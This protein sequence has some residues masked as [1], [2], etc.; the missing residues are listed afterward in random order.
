MNGNLHY[1]ID[2]YKKFGMNHIIKWILPSL[3]IF[4]TFVSLSF[5]IEKIDK[6]LNGEDLNSMAWK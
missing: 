2:R 4:N 3:I 5:Q 1:E 6:T